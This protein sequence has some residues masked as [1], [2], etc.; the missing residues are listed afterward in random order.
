MGKRPICC[1]QGVKKQVMN[2]EQYAKIVA[3]IAA[4]ET[5]HKSFKRRLDDH[6][7]ALKKQ[8][9]ILIVMER[10]S[11]AIEKMGGAVGRV[12]KK[13]DSIDTR[14]GQLEK[15]PADKWKKMSLEIIKYILIAAVGFAVS[16]LFKGTP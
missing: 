13:V 14:V 15:E 6:D 16:Y 12:E 9:D 2:E 5:E 7:E 10:Q 3:D 1:G 8:G 11:A 4:N